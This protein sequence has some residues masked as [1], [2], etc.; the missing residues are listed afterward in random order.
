MYTDKPSSAYEPAFDDAQRWWSKMR[1]PVTFTGVPGHPQHPAVL[2]NTGLLFSPLLYAGPL[3]GRGLKL[4]GPP[5]LMRELEGYETDGLQVGFSLGPGF[6]FPD[7]GDNTGGEVSQRLVEGRMPIVVSEVHRGELDWTCT[8]FSRLARGRQ[9]R[10]GKEPL[11]TEVRWQV[12][13]VSSS[14]AEMQLACHLAAPHVTLGYK[15]AVRETALPYQRALR[16]SAPLL[17]DDRGKARLAAVLEGGAALAFHRTLP[18]EL[19]GRAETPL[20]ALGLDQDVLFLQAEMVPGQSVALRLII[21][22]FAVEPEALAGALEVS[23]D[24]AL[25]RAT[26]S[27]QRTFAAAGRIDPPEE[28]VRDCCDAYLAQAMLATGRRAR[29]GHWILKTSPNHYEGLWG[30]HAAIAAYSMDLRK[31]HELSRHVLETFLANQGPI[32]QSIITLFSD[33]PVGESEG[34]DDHPGFLGNIEGHMAVLWAF[35]HGWIMWAIGQHAR[36]TGDWDWFRGH[37]DRLALACE[38][39]ARQRRRTQLAEPTGER[40]LAYG[41]LPAA[42]AFDWGFGHMFWS[43]AHTYRGL[44]EIAD[45][46]ARIGHPRAAEFLAEAAAYQQDIITAVARCRDASPPVPLD[47]GR[48]LPF[49]PM[50]AEMRDYFAPDWT[51]V[52]CGP[53]NL[54]WAGVVPADH[55][56]IEQTLAVLEAGRPLGEWDEK[57]GKYQGWDWASRTPAD[58]DFLDATRPPSGRCHWWRHKMTYE[59]G[60]IPQAFVFMARDDLPALFE[61]LYSLLSHGGQHVDLRSP[62]EQRDGVPWTQPGQANLL[63]LMRS[64]LVREEGDALLLA[65]SCPRAWYEAGKRIAVEGLPTWFGEVSYSL[66]VAADEASVEFDP[67]F[68]EAPREVRVRIRHPEGKLPRRVAI[69]G[70]LTEQQGCEWIALPAGKC[71][72]AISF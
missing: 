25:R 60:W 11:L 38:W 36:L 62:I 54:A 8:V 16:W 32:P 14:S 9:A 70:Q 40:C 35:Y 39:I 23:F 13:S 43:D 42:N 17:L 20:E 12:R 10:T 64:M 4:S 2:W 69:N 37:A 52:A 28:L 33:R 56:L 55:E 72:V 6:H 50:S 53:L 30:A 68:R 27:W 47:D 58:D 71:R 57:A 46:L 65:S 41:L 22:Y 18:K 1:R 21:P 67:S 26:R 29:A 5:G 34:F 3:E 51:Y 19:A 66:A 61:H 7:R 63:W 45:C 49:V 24:E 44:R 15:V 48:T 59:P 31:Q